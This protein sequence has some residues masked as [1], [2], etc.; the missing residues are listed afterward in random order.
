MFT[1]FHTLDDKL[2]EQLNGRAFPDSSLFFDIETT[3]LDHRRSH[4]YLLGMIFQENGS[5]KLVQLFAEKP[6]EET[7]ILEA[8]AKRLSVSSPLIYFNGTAFDIPYLQHRCDFH[9]LPL[10]WPD[11]PG[12]DLYRRIRPFQKLLDLPQCRQKDC[13][14]FCGIF[15]EDPFSG[16]QLTEVYRSYLETGEMR[17]KKALML[18]NRDDMEGMVKILPLLSY[19]SL[20]EGQFHLIS[21]NVSPEEQLCRLM[22]KLDFPLPRPLF[23]RRGAVHAEIS[24]SQLL[25]TVP[26]FIGTLKY[27]Y[28]NYK[29]YY[30][31]PEEDQAVHKSVGAYVD[32][33]HRRQARA[34]DCYQKKDG[35][36]LPQFS[37]FHT[38]SFRTAL[39]E[40]SSYFLFREEEWL[41]ES[42]LPTAYAAH[43]IKELLRMPD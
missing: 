38:P 36:F 28:S 15:R 13:E 34:F 19:S 30:Y 6:A 24:G 16:G 42:E 7:E 4:L 41:P 10:S 37:D 26:L 17:L 21:R 8:F 25:L 1:E 33:A 5:W 27:F 39:R 32:K 14:I 18:H 43:L 3:G 9:G 2:Q 11:S 20:Q 22:L 23:L 40:T 12:L 31:L 29:D 35:I